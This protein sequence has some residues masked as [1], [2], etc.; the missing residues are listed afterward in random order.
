MILTLIHPTDPDKGTSCNNCPS[1]AVYKVQAR[2]ASLRF[3]TE[4]AN[5]LSS[6][7]APLRNPSAQR[8]KR[9]LAKALVL[10]KKNLT[11]NNTLIKVCIHCGYASGSH[12][13]TCPYDQ[14]MKEIDKI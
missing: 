6:E 2:S 8:N 5:Q 3:C 7:L 14:L 11:T 4:C 10:L 9:L 12:S 13:P 1:P